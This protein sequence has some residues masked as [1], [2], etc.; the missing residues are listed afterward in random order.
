M[1]LSGLHPLHVHGRARSR[2]GAGA[3]VR[4]RA[5][6][7]ELRQ[8]GPSPCP[9]GRGTAALAA[10]SPRWLR[11]IAGGRGSAGILRA[12]A[13]QV[14]LRATRTGILVNDPYP[15]LSKASPLIPPNSQPITL[16]FDQVQTL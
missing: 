1:A 5:L 3:P 6:S 16:I 4:R 8:P 10:A 13:C 7:D 15:H 12:A 14:G 2:P 11:C 9:R